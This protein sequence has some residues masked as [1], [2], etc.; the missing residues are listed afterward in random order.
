MFYKKILVITGLLFSNIIHAQL[1]ND[2]LEI[3]HKLMRSYTDNIPGAQVSI[4]RN[5]KIIFESAKGL[6]NL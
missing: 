5:N 3:L 4:T 6:A 1:S 2:T